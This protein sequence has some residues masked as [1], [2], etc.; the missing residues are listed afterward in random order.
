MTDFSTIDAS[1]LG[2]VLGGFSL[3]QLGRSALAGFLDGGSQ[4]VQSGQGFLASALR[5]GIMGFAQGFAGQIGTGGEQ[6]S[7][8]PPQGQPQ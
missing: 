2:L 3:Q 7:G 1:E 5:G 8:P 4:G 6:P